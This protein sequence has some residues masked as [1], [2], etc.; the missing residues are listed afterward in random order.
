[1]LAGDATLIPLLQRLAVRDVRVTLTS[2]LSVPSSI[3]PPPLVALADTCID[4]TE[5]NRFLLPEDG[6]GRHKL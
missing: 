1:M 2:S 5:D 3:A 4:Q 6:H